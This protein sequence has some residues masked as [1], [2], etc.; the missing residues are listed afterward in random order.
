MGL[1]GGKNPLLIG[2]GSFRV[3]ELFCYLSSN[4]S[5]IETHAGFSEADYQLEERGE[6]TIVQFRA[7]VLSR[8]TS[9][10]V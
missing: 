1:G 9:P 3:G 10:G 7:A 8:Q 5:P 4:P 2:W 6:W